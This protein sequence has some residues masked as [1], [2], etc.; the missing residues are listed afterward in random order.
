VD[1]DTYQ[2]LFPNKKES[3]AVIVKIKLLM[4][5]KCILS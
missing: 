2:F 5:F 1:V 3:W 4:S